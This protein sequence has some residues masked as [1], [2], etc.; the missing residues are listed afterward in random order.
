MG[1]PNS[2]WKEY[3]ANEISHSMAHYLVTLRD[4]HTENGYA[5]ITDIA[6]ELGV[7]KS[8][9]SFEVRRLKDLGFVREDRARHLS[10]TESGES[11][12]RQIVYNRATLI[13]FL[14]TILRVD[15]EQAQI[16]ACKMEHLLSPTTGHKVMGLVQLLLSHEAAAQSFRRKFARECQKARHDTGVSVARE[17]SQ[18]G[19]EDKSKTTP[20]GGAK[21]RRTAARKKQGATTRTPRSSKKKKNRP[22]TK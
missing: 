10:L 14:T 17:A 21:T 15:D 3:N 19:A 18:V 9:V 11:V 20:S 22:S 5:R 1:N 13:H 2:T 12:A 16:D 4:L 7:T 8:A 6:D